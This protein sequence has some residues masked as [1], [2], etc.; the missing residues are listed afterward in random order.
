MRCRCLLFATTAIAV[1][2]GASALFLAEWQP[3]T[4][5]TVFENVSLMFPFAD[6]STHQ[7][8]GIV[9]QGRVERV[10]ADDLTVDHLFNVSEG[11]RYLCACYSPLTRSLGILIAHS[12]E[13]PTTNSKDRSI[14]LR[15]RLEVLRLMDGL[16]PLVVDDVLKA[17]RS[18]AMADT[19]AI[20]Q[21]EFLNAGR[22]IHLQT[23]GEADDEA[24]STIWRVSD[25]TVLLDA[26][27]GRGFQKGLGT[28]F[29]VFGR[30]GHLETY[31]AWIPSHGTV[32]MTSA[33]EYKSASVV[34][35]WLALAIVGGSC[36]WCICKRSSAR[37]S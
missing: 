13:K 36:G 31:F 4:T 9:R 2:L 19:P 35:L 33:R 20:R 28:E 12:A 26:P 24:W 34:L 21:F 37:P 32:E 22:W 3:R 30:D 5:K 23:E 15:N 18:P 10:H 11:E 25:G 1:V 17:K 8:F 27:A 29:E 14:S 16:K 6:H 7:C